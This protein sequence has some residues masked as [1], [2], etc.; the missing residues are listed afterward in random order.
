MNREVSRHV[1]LQ[2]G[3]TSGIVYDL[4]MNVWM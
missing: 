1:E 3:W 2:I 4:D